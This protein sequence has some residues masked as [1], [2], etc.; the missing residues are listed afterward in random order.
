[1]AAWQRVFGHSHP[2]ENQQRGIELALDVFS[3]NGYLALEGACGTGKTMLAL[4]AGIQAVRDRSTPFERILV[5]TSVKQQLRQFERDLA[6][7][8]SNRPE[9]MDPVT[10]LTLV[11]KADVCPYNLTGT[12]GMTNTSLYDRCESLRDRTRELVDGGRQPS[13]LANQAQTQFGQLEI[14]GTEAP[15]SEVM[16]TA[17]MSDSGR[18]VE[19][20]PFYAQYLADSQDGGDNSNPVLFEYH[21]GE[22]LTPEVLVQR[23][24]EF[25]SCPHSLMGVLLE[26][27]EVVIGN[28]YHVFDPR[29]VTAFT[30]GLLDQST[31]LI[32]DEAHMLE[33][34]VRDLASDQVAFG[35]LERAR[36]ELATVIEAAK[37]REG[38]GAETIANETLSKAGFDRAD[39]SLVHTFLGE[40]LAEARISTEERVTDDRIPLRDPNEINTDR[41]TNQMVNDGYGE[42]AWEAA[43]E[44]APCVEYILNTLDGEER[45]RALPGVGRFLNNWYHRDHETYLRSISPRADDED[46]ALELHNCLPADVIAE[47]LDAFGGGILMSATLAPTDVFTRVTGLDRIAASGR[48]VETAQFGLP[49]LRE[50]RLSLIVDAP[51]FTYRNRGSPAE[52]TPTRRVYA[53]AIA[54]VAG[55]A[56]GNTLVGMPSYAEARWAA[57]EL[58]DRIDRPVLLDRSSDRATTEALKSEFFEGG[59]KVLVTSL[60]GTLTEGVDYEGDRLAAA[61]VCGVPIINTGDPVTQAMTTAYDRRF[62]HGFEHSLVV[63]A[64]R[65]ARQALGRV[66]RGPDEV[67]VRVLVDERF[68][69]SGWDGVRDHLPTS[70]EFEVIHAEELPGTLDR[71][72]ERH[73]T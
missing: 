10:A 69:R 6:Q 15:Y 64:V 20:C 46:D 28:Y 34:R 24:L 70:G 49:F 12:G 23:G 54:D 52:Q 9:E 1:M 61:V 33:P 32:C 51:K 43:Q 14:D 16:P 72:W 13:V 42:S 31:L 39:L 30:G 66:I 56:D 37:G 22:V 59:P 58:E 62:G 4:T 36:N 25:G 67:G 3:D 57:D 71:F 19:F 7:I 17:D 26:E 5:A 21:D 35:T 2:Y 8:E 45:W 60:R 53:T 47:R 38:R 11:G 40:L 48:P 63:P 29:T 55:S 41:L 73:D 50:N 18:D 44:L 27:V 65:K 68:H